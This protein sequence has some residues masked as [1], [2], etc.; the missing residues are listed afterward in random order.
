V[1]KKF[2]VN[3]AIIIISLIISISLIG[4][5]LANAKYVR[6]SDVTVLL[7]LREYRIAE[8]E[9]VVEPD[10]DTLYKVDVTITG[11]KP[12]VKVNYKLGED[13]EWQEYVG[14]FEVTENTVVR[15]RY[16]GENFNGPITSKEIKNILGPAAKTEINGVETEYMSLQEA[17]DAA[18]TNTATVTLL[19]DIVKESVV[20]NLNSNITIDLN[21]KVWKN[22]SE[23]LNT[24]TVNSGTVTI[25]GTGKILAKETAV[26]VIGTAAN[27]LDEVAIE[28]EKIGISTVDGIVVIG[29]DTTEVNK[30]WP[31]VMGKE[32]GIVEN[33]NNTISYYDGNIKA[34]NGKGS[35]INAKVDNLPY[36]Y[37]MNIHQQTIEE[38]LVEYIDLITF[39]PLDK[40]ENVNVKIKKL[41]GT[42]ASSY[43]SSDYNVKEIRKSDI[44]PDLSTMNEGNIVSEEN[45]KYKIYMWFDNGIIYWWSDAERVN[46]KYGRYMFFAF[47]NLT[48]LEGLREWNLLSIKDGLYQMFKSCESLTQINALQ[49]WDTSNLTE[50]SCLFEY[51]KSLSNIDGLKNWDTK[52]VT[53]LTRAFSYTNLKDH[54]LT[55]Q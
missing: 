19:K 45:S 11:N 31:S 55:S 52:K 17:I 37:D 36:G 35:A 12:G 27:I 26:N 51:C 34:E 43:S 23:N 8:S 42:Q 16:V 5:F 2:N 6:K 40:G 10:T 54:L 24:F 25:K 13:G 4:I 32:Y 41:A 1:K 3:I 20:K 21:G 30:M 38:V 39:S 7:N 22:D 48:E 44:K 49:D 18:G 29:D 47:R 46:L 9:I 50:L 33:E 53:S 28:S 14:K 15:A